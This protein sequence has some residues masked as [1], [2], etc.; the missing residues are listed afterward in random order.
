MANWAAKPSNPAIED[1]HKPPLIHALIEARTN[2]FTL[3]VVEGADHAFS[4][5]EY[6]EKGEMLGER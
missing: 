1:P 3:K 5:K 6:A 2:D 4:S